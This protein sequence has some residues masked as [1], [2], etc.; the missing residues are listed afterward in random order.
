MAKPK[1]HPSK[2]MAKIKAIEAHVFFPK[3]CI[4]L[5]P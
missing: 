3:T 5:I 2:M 1:R 4:V